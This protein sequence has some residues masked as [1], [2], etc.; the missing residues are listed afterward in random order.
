MYQLNASRVFI[1]FSHAPKKQRKKHDGHCYS[2]HN[3]TPFPFKLTIQISHFLF[4]CT[5]LFRFGQHRG[6]VW[7]GFD[8]FKVPLVRFRHE[9]PFFDVILQP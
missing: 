9:M 1:Q 7:H 3:H 6:N 5:G 2:Y 4:D 8:N